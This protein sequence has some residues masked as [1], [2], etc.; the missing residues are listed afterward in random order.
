MPTT[1]PATMPT[2]APTVQ[3]SVPV[4]HRP[5]PPPPPPQLGTATPEPVQR[6][7]PIPTTQPATIPT[8]VITPT[9]QPGPIDEK[10]A[11]AI[12]Y[13]VG[14]RIHARLSEDGRDANNLQV[15]NGILAG[16]DGREPV[17]P[18]EDIQAAFAQFQAYTL[19]RRAEKQYADDPAFRKLADEN[20]QISHALMAQNAEMV[21]VESRPDGVQ[22]LLLKAGAGPVLGG[23]KS[24]TINLKVS[25]ADGTLVKAN[26]P[27]KP[28]V[29]AATDCLPSVIDASR[30][31]KVGG[32]WRVLVPPDK[33]YGLS[34]KSPLIGPNQAIEYEVELVAIEDSDP[35]A[36]AVQSSQTHGSMKSADDYRDALQRLEDSEAA[37]VQARESAMK[38]A[39]SA[40]NYLAAVKDLDT[41]Y[42]AFN[43][44]RMALLSDLE[45]KDPR[46][47]PMK[48]RAMDIDAE[49]DAALQNPATTREHFESLCSNRAI[50]IHQWEDLENSAIDR[51][52]LTPLRQ[53]WIDASQR[54]STLRNQQRNDVES[55]EKV[56]AALAAVA[57]AQAAA[58]QARA[59]FDGPQ[60]TDDL[61]GDQAQDYLR[62]FPRFIGS[63][64]DALW[65]Y[66]WTPVYGATPAAKPPTGK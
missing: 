42:A 4:K 49:M 23:A 55:S 16:M 12:G 21:N 32:T 40:A 28:Q 10:V 43:D 34:G 54:L 20:L 17:Y 25:L 38:E 14:R 24:L 15:L 48:K 2:T 36:Q 29:I 8:A 56:K 26:L 66:G 45:K 5:V 19:Q 65:T 39:Q 58:V 46:F 7:K 63:G 50:F 6:A 52:G 30:E 11:Y 27:G 37:L 44:K 60:S 51:A 9:T 62:R 53:Q 35:K 33:A 3:P 22:V 31:M 64:E 41:A 18:R 61:P 59:V 13:S 1:V 57:Q 47:G